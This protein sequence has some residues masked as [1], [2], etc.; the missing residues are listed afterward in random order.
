MDRSSTWEVNPEGGKDNGASYEVLAW[1]RDKESGEPVYIM[2]L[3]DKH[4][5]AKCGC[6]CPS[7]NLDLIAVNVGK[8]EY[9][10]RPHF[11]HPAGAIKSDCM[12]ISARLAAMRL[13]KSDGFILLPKR[14]RTATAIGIS[15]TQYGGFFETQPHRIG[16]RDFSFRDKAVAIL[17]LADG[18]KLHVDLVGKG[19]VLSE[20]GK[21]TA[22]I[23]LNIN[24]PEI[25]GMSLDDLRA[26]IALIPDHLCW[27]AHWDDD[28]LTAKA[29]ADAESKADDFMD[30]QSKYAADLEF[31]DKNL[32]HETVL[33]WEVKNIL[34]EAMELRVPKLEVQASKQATNGQ[35]IQKVWTI[36]S[37][38][39]PLLSVKTEQRLGSLI[40]DVIAQTPPEHG[41]TLIV[42]V[43]VTNTI[44]A[45][46][47]NRIRQQNLPTLEIDLSRSGGLVSRAELKQIVL[48]GLEL[49]RWIHHPERDKHFEI[50]TSQVESEVFE[51]NARLLKQ[52]RDRQEVLDTP[53]AT[54]VDEY[55]SMIM[56]IAEF[57]TLDSMQTGDRT[58]LKS[59]EGDLKGVSKKLSIHGYPEAGDEELTIGRKGIIPRL[60]SI[61]LGRGV[62][63]KLNSTMEV[64]N[65]IK[66]SSGRNSFNHSIY[67]AAEK[68]YRPADFTENPSWYVE[69]VNEV[70]RGINSRDITYKPDGKYFKFLAV[71]FPEMAN[72]LSKLLRNS[73]QSNFDAQRQFEYNTEWW[74]NNKK[75]HRLDVAIQR[76]KDVFKYRGLSV[77]PNDVL[78]E[79][80]SISDG[81]TYLK[82]FQIWNDRYV[83]PQATYYIA[84]MLEVA[85]YT[86]AMKQWN[87][88]TVHETSKS[89]VQNIYSSAQKDSKDALDGNVSV[90]S[91]LN[92]YSS[93]TQQSIDRNL[94]A[95]MKGRSGPRKS[96]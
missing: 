20:D 65:A 28:E 15:G 71:V 93:S 45:E 69:W 57:D 74:R 33:H 96:K 59:L 32:R 50:L 42:E 61:R 87:D 43:T 76:A 88:W 19:A 10:R 82:W 12:F 29:M 9:K 86:D 94:Y 51:L 16:I 55:I 64:M 11:R 79:A 62:G 4:A 6:E 3:D 73:S 1:A 46:R 72:A 21:Q 41:S 13:F 37:H 58:K 36:D 35:Q 60:L 90:G 7:C 25:A 85:G 24:D 91:V 70:K 47:I 89:S 39:I 22:C 5:G 26:N 54:I 48:N 75:K 23:T 8:T 49:K 53:I 34:A 31:I 40:P 44:D 56:D 30:L 92:R 78:K 80:E 77:N 84:K 66:Q 27:I 14:Y 17:T 18:R 67:M 52:Q 81:D 68:V 63:Y 38:V 2:E 95:E 83:N